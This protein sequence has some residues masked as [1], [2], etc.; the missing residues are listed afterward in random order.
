MVEVEN[1]C[2]AAGRGQVTRCDFLR[3]ECPEGKDSRDGGLL[4]A[5]PS[6]T[7]LSTATTDTSWPSAA[8]PSARSWTT[9]SMPPER[10]Q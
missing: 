10:G 5:D 8:A 1:V 4:P 3:A 7:L 6:P 2:P 9:R